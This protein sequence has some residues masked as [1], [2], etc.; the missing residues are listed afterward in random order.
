M[1]IQRPVTQITTQR[2]GRPAGVMRR[3]EN[4]IGCAGVHALKEAGLI[5]VPVTVARELALYCG[6]PVAEATDVPAEVAP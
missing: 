5:I 2:R 1:S 6:E 3:A 4:L